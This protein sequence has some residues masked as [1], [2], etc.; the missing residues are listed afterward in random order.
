LKGFQITPGD[1]EFL[2]FLF[3]SCPE[4]NNK[5]EDKIKCNDDVVCKSQHNIK[6][7]INIQQFINHHF[8]DFVS[9]GGNILLPGQ[10]LKM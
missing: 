9:P 8:I 4:S 3:S 1:K 2:L 6:F 7:T 5:D 10:A